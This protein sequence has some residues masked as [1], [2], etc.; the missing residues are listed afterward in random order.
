VTT[1]ASPRSST[2][3]PDADECGQL[4][5]STTRRRKQQI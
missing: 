1:T 3:S 5:Q 4:A 2:S